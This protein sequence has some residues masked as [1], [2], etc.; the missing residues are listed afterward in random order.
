[1]NFFA[2]TFSE[3]QDWKQLCTAFADQEVPVCVTGLSAVHKA[4]LALTLAGHSEKPIL[5]LTGSEADAIKLCADINAMSG[6]TIALHYPSKELLFTAAESK[7]AEYEHE[8]L[9]VLSAINRGEVRIAAAGIEAALQPTIP[10]QVLRDAHITL[11]SGGS[12]NLQ[13]LTEKLIASGY[14]RCENVEG[15]GQFAIRGSIVDIFP[16]QRTT[17]IRMEMWGDDIDV[18]M[19][20]DPET[21]RRTEEIQEVT[22]SPASELLYAPEELIEKINAF[23]AKVRGKRTQQIREHL[24]HDVQ[25]LDAGLTLANADKYYSLLYPQTTLADYADGHVLLCE[26]ADI[27]KHAQSLQSQHREDLQILFEDG[28]LCRGL[29]GNL[30]EFADLQAML[31]K[32]CCAYLSQFLQGT[33]RVPFR[34]I[35][36][37]EA[38]QTATW[39]GEIRLLLEDLQEYTSQG[40]RVVLAAGSEKTLPILCKDLQESGIRCAI[41]QE[42]DL[43]P[44]GAVLLTARQ[45]SAGFA[46]QDNKTAL[47]VQ[48]KMHAAKRKKPKHKAGMEIRTLSDLHAG[49]LVVHAMHGVGRFLGINKIEMEGIA[50]D[51]I[52]IQYAGTEKLYVPV[53]QLDLVSKYIGAQDDNAVKLNRLSS[54]QWQKTC[55]NVRKAVRD[56]AEELM[57]LYAK[58]E[59]SE[60]Y[61]FYPDDE[62]QHEFEERFPY[63]ETDDQMQ[64]VQEIKSDMERPRPMDRLLCGDVGFGKTEVAFRAAMKCVLSNRQCAILTPTTVLAL[65]HYRTALRRFDRMPVRIEMLSRFRTAKEQ[66]KI[67]EDLKKGKIDIIIGTHRIVQKDVEFHALGLAI[68]D[69]EQRF[70]VAHKERF[71]EMFAGIDVLTLSATPIPR[72]LNMALSGIRDMSVLADPPQDRY[73]VQTY[74]TEYQEGTVMQA[75]GRELKRGGQV[76]Y[77]HNRVDTI[78]HCASRLQQMFPDA[79][80]AV[81]HGKL[82]EDEM[83]EIWRQVVDGEADILVCTTIIETGVDVANA[84]TLIIEDADRL[85]LSQLYQLRGRVGRSNRRAYAYFMFKRDKVLTEVASKRLEAMREFTQ[86]GSGF[87]IAMRDLEIRGAGSILGGR[88]HGHMETVGYDMYMQMLNDAIAEVKGEKVKRAAAC[89]VDIQIE[90]YIPEEYI[91]STASR[92]DMYRKIATVRDEEDKWELA[93]ELCDRYGEPPKAIMGLITVSMLRNT[94]AGMGITE[95]TQRS[96]SLQ[97]YIESPEPEQIAALSQKYGRRILFSCM[98]KPFIGV[99]LLPNQQPAMLMQEVIMCMKGAVKG[100]QST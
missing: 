36:S 45:I 23:S 60:G 14:S 37:I 77:L 42:D 78:I 13:E 34:K 64:S 55:N 93:D 9:H 100:K 10:P 70:G 75:I 30:L 82:S 65:Q 63:A 7:S 67:L 38:Q 54:P 16:V 27:V 92:I 74:V 56:M 2:D 41:A 49:D 18:I 69:E 25:R 98:E 32:R 84:N 87:R 5:L 47:I 44:P 22:I 96:G 81:A 52:T 85:G 46:Y 12:V 99:K 79:R 57:K 29:D 15:K 6:Q 83:S 39:G 53:T 26:Y 95:I 61:A 86:F 11:H 20:F 48:T 76:Y 3:L 72:T 73:P 40:Y 66:K 88:Q 94:A 58:R 62:I 1:M 24:E 71:K 89:T 91:E 8:R 17:P 33:E 21:Q 97:F 90:A 28:V 59:K 51:Y 68:I 31:E 4:Q 19:E 80:I 43:C 35:I 50:K